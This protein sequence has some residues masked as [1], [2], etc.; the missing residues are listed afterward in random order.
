MI[1][2]EIKIRVRY[3]EVDRMGH[4]Y[5]GNYATYFEM[6]R[7]E[8]LRGHG[9]VYKDLEDSGI[10]MPLSEFSVKYY[11]PAHY[12]DE[13]ILHTKMNMPKGVR[14]I[15]DY[16]L[17]NSERVL[18]AEGITSLVF[19]DSKTRRPIRPPKNLVEQFS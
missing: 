16:N 17:Y 10:I 15:F 19:V 18:L 4:V 13:L 3:A 2:G 5:N 11:K 6:G 7:T 12:D 14:L 9:L 8:L 1:E